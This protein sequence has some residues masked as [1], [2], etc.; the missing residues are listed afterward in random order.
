MQALIA[1]L[2]ALLFAG[3]ANLTPYTAAYHQ[4]DPRLA[5][6]GWN[7]GCAGLKYRDQLSVATGYCWDFRGEVNVAEVRLEYDWRKP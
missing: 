3:C 1:I 2:V 5:D 6:D 4:S 7:W